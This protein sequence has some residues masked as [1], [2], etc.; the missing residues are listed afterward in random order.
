[1]KTV[2]LCV[3]PVWKCFVSEKYIF[4]N[5]YGKIKN[6]IKYKIL[7]NK[8]FCVFYKIE[9]SWN[10]CRILFLQHFFLEFLWKKH[11]N[12]ENFWF[13]KNSVKSLADWC[14]L[15]LRKNIRKRGSRYKTKKHIFSLEK[16]SIK[17]YNLSVKKY[18]KTGYDVL[19]IE[20]I[21]NFWYNKKFMSENVKN[22]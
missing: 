5:I 19:F 8:E 6:V 7:D 18:H 2:M 1:M 16:C 3:L 22:C 14:F 13:Y 17:L 11:K 20:Y 9:K 4:F 21:N 15:T 10:K 12:Q